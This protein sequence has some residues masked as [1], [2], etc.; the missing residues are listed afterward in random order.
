M[1][2]GHGVVGI[3]PEDGNKDDQKAGAPLLQEQSERAGACQ[4]GE[5]DGETLQRDFDKLFGWTVSSCIKFDKSIF[6]ILYLG[7]DNPGYMYRLEDEKLESSPEEK[8]LEILN[9]GKFSMSQQVPSDVFFVNSLWKGFYEYLGK[10]QP[11]TLTIDWFNTTSSKV[12]A[13]FTEASSLQLKLS[14][15]Y[16][17]EEAHLLLKIFQIR[18]SNDIFLN[19]FE[20]DNWALDGYVSSGLERGV[21]TYQGDIHGKDFGKF[22]L[23]RQGPLSADTDLSNHYYGTNS[24]SVAAAILVPFFALILSGFA[25]YLYKHRTRPKVQY[26]GYAGHENSNGQASF[27]NPMYDTN[28]KPTEAKAVRF[29]T[30]LNTVCTV[31]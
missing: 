20:N 13:T 3:G 6:K 4:P 19:K 11:A 17:K 24:S 26:N 7:W 9:D 14:G 1:Q 28:L 31:V 8:N 22:M 30:T 25:F 21:F 15:V 2:E 12:N 18:G 23:Q 27:E 5:K 29:D 16:K 10:R